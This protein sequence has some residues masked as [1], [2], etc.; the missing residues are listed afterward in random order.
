M[1]REPLLTR[2][3]LLCAVANLAQGTAFN[4]FLHVAGFL[5]QL[6]ADDLE[7]GLIYGLTAAVAI[8]VRRPL[9]PYVDRHGY[10]AVI[11]V[12]GVLNAGVCAL[13]LTVETMG[14]AIYALRVLHGLAEAL[15]FTAFFGYAADHVP[16]ARRTEGLALFGVSGMLPIALGGLLGEWALARGGFADLFVLATALALLSLLLSLPLRDR[17]RV[18]PADL[19]GRG[20]WGA[21]GQR[22]L[23]PL[24]WLGTVFALALTSAFAFLRRFVDETGVGSVG[25]FFAAYAAAAIVLRVGLGWLPDRVGPKRVLFPALVALAAGFLALAGARDARDVVVAGVLCGIGHGYVFPIL[26]ALVVSRARAADRGS[27][28]AIFTALFD[29]GVVL[30]GPLFGLL[31]RG[32]D[33]SW[34]FATAA[35]VIVFG[36]GIFGF[37]DRQALA[38]R[39]PA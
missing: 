30:G 38:A 13:Y 24:W 23:L 25:E 18:D 28:S 3:F 16:A 36:T 20:F 2:A 5:N 9:G 39:V 8:V 37:W 7:I 27:A 29:V 11:L 19:P 31:S 26:F 35:G 1:A 6:G 22:D 14:P 12:G 10:R 34:T 33:F 4:L 17:P 32:L 21:L 15:L